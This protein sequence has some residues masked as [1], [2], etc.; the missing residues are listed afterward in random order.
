[1]VYI[2]AVGLPAAYEIVL[3][4][5]TRLWSLVNSHKQEIGDNG[6][7]RWPPAGQRTGKAILDL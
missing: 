1:M 5:P 7:D 3:Q 6:I 4:Y 2:I